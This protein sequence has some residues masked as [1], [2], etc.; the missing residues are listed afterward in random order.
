MTVFLARTAAVALGGALGAVGRYCISGWVSRLFTPSVFPWG[1]LTVNVVGAFVLG[2]FVGATA[3]G[4]LAVSPN[5]RVFVTIG[6]LGAFTTFSTFAYENLEALRVGDVRSA[7]LNIGAS[8]LVG[9][10]ACWIGL[11]VGQR[12]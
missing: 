4:R 2:A 11:A 8:L 1:T 9:L 3:F 12:L 7:I 5:L 10:A 6:V